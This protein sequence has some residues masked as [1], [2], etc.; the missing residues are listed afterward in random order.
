[1]TKVIFLPSSDL[2]VVVVPKSDD[3]T[4]AM[5]ATCS[6]KELIKLAAKEI[7]PGKD[8]NLT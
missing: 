5:I 4:K 7:T 3:P 8:R 6:E 1:M 2:H